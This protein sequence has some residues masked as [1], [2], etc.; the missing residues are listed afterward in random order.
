MIKFFRKMTNILKEGLKGIWVHR[1]M[2]FAS[3]VATFATLFVIGLVI[4]ITVTVNNIA[5]DI[6]G[7][8]DEVEIFLQVG[9]DKIKEFEVETKIKDF[10][11][12]LTYKYKSSKEALDIM[13]ETWGENADLLEGITSDKLLPASFVVHLE[14]ISQADKFV[15]YIKKSD[16][17]DEVNYYKDLVDKAYKISRY[18]QM[19]GVALVAIL[20][21]VSLF[22]I[23]N[24]IKL[25]VLSRKEEIRVMKYVGATNSYIRIPFIIEG[26]FFG[27]LGSAL[28]FLAVYLGYR[29]GY[30]YY[31]NNIME[32]FSVI[33]LVKPMY[34]KWPLLQIFAAMGIGIGLVGGAFSIRK[35]LK[36]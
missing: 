23:S 33:S 16:S 10:S 30:I 3:V 21:V 29:A 13:K 6:E 31:N 22:I 34:F 26:M 2:G 24:T 15:E 14:D 17:V 5:S 7:K 8:V 9:T 11:G 27:L 18:V 25:T 12:N 20:L 36:V 4:I 28:A 32:S 1:S 19:F 35:Y